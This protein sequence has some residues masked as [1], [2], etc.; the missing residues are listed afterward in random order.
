MLAGLHLCVITDPGL[1]PGKDH[2]AIA[3][4]ALRGGADM[5][6]LRDKAGDLR[7]LLR[8]A[9]AIHALC[10]AQGALFIV[11]DRVDLAL[12]AGADGAHVGQD[13]LPAEAARRLL[14]AGRLLGVSTHSPDQARAAE[15]AGADYIGF[16]PMFP[17]GTKDTG[18][19]PQGLTALPEVRRATRLPILAIG[20]ITLEN[21]TGVIQAGATAPA[22]I[23][24]V[25]AAPDIAAAAAAFRQRVAFAKS[26]SWDPGPPGASEKGHGR[27]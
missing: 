1:A 19:L 17:T 25:V 24:A 6:Q 9:R 4:A 10:R 22:V 16:G 27:R 7:D 20:G 12:A 5:I 21:V 26:S 15:K 11:N 18:Y 3:E 14:G 13:D 23:S 2:V 8:Q